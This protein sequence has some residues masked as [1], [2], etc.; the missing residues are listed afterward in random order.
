MNADTTWPSA[1]PAPRRPTLPDLFAASGG[2]LPSAV[3][4]SEMVATGFGLALAL[5]VVA[6][7]LAAPLAGWLGL[8]TLVPEPSA[9]LASLA[10]LTLGTMLAAHVLHRQHARPLGLAGADARYAY[11]AAGRRRMATGL[12]A[13]YLTAATLTLVVVSATG[14]QVEL[15]RLLAY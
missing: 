10:G 15:A 2:S 9:T 3:I 5:L 6:H 14:A 1:S 12:V 8:R 7:G 13:A 11:T 4:A